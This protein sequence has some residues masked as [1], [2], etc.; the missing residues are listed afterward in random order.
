[1]SINLIHKPVDQEPVKITFNNFNEVLDYI[2][3][4][5]DGPK[6][7]FTV[8]M[9]SRLRSSSLLKPYEITGIGILDRMSRKSDERPSFFIIRGDRSVYN[10]LTRLYRTKDERH[11]VPDFCEAIHI[12]EWSSYQDA[13]DYC[14]EIARSSSV[15][16]RP[17]TA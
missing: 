4:E 7:V 11:V 1:M 2:D 3:E 9:Q 10:E 17:P 14:L 5:I 16:L 6:L 13:F 12:C 15:G 8:F